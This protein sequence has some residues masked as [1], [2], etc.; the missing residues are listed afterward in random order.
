MKNNLKK[1]LKYLITI[2]IVVVSVY[3]S[4]RDINLQR[5]WEIL[6]NANY[7]FALLPI[8]V[9]VASHWTRALRWRTMLEP[10]LKK[11]TPATINLF[12]AVMI[13]YAVNC[14]LP[15][16]GEFVRPYVYARR[17]KVSYTTTFATII[18]ERFIDLVTLF[19]LFA[20]A[21][22]VFGDIVVK[23]LPAKIDINAIITLIVLFALV[24]IFSF[25]PPFF[26]KFIQIL[27]KPFSEKFYNRI[28]ELYE[29]FLKGFTIIKTPSRY[30]RVS[31]DSIL[32]WFFYTIPLYM[33]FF[34]FPFQQEYNL[35]FDA[36]I[37]LIIVSGVG[38]TIAPTPGAVGI[39][40]WL[41][42]D[43][44]HNL[45]GIPKEESLAFAA[46]AHFV[47]Y[48]IQIS[49]GG[50]FF[51]RENIK[52]LPDEKDISALRKEQNGQTDQ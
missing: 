39:Y 2:I 21:F 42:R 6:I 50:F 43:A 27:L 33:T 12:S 47:S 28:S 31:F 13:G 20:F 5:L 4:L 52:S 30:L 1:I 38:V 10:A 34:A 23:S 7:I 29:K 9:I 32:I 36:A 49:V 40:H 45:Y 17:E 16:G 19:L 15:R 51:F 41:I 3:L 14:V 25:Y 8:P 18:A 35:G 11:K 24:L 26:R 46:V 48:M 37:F 44:L 22:I